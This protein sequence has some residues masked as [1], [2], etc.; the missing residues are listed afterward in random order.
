MSVFSIKK[1]F[2]IVFDVFLGYLYII[3][4]TNCKSDFLSEFL[5]EIWLE[6]IFF[7]IVIRF[8]LN[9]ISIVVIF[10]WWYL[11]IN[12]IM[13]YKDFIGVGAIGL[14]KVKPSVGLVKLAFIELVI[15]VV[16]IIW[17][18]MVMVKLSIGLVKLAFIVK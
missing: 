16:I 12:L 2:W 9:Q 1:L 10:V 7:L 13:P 6:L 11:N 15:V 4:L 14:F 8:I 17:F 5:F 18:I 3:L